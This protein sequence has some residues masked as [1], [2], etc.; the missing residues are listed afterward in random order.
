[1]RGSARC[2]TSAEAAELGARTAALHQGGSDPG[3][4]VS[5]PRFPVCQMWKRHPGHVAASPSQA[6]LGAPVHT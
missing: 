3:V 4:W 6:P 5:G 1:M 2:P